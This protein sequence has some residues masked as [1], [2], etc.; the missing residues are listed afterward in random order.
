MNFKQLFGP[1]IL[2]FF[3]LTP[4]NRI[5]A[6]YCFF[7]LF[8]LSSAQLFSLKL[9][10]KTTQ[11]PREAKQRIWIF[12]LIPAASII[13]YIFSPL[14]NLSVKTLEP[15]SRWLLFIPIFIATLHNRLH[16][17]WVFTALCIYCISAFSKGL[18]ET[19]FATELWRRA[20]GDENPNPFGM[21]NATVSLMLICYLLYF[22]KDSNRPTLKN[23]GV[24]SLTC[25]CI[26]L[27][28]ISTYLTG[29]RTALF[30]L[31]IGTLIFLI[32]NIKS[33]LSWATIIS[34]IILFSYL[35][36]TP[37][38][39]ILKEKIKSIP[40]KTSAFLVKGDQS[41]KLNSTGQRLE[42]WR[43]SIC[44]F[45][46]HPITGTGPRSAR[47]AFGEYGGEQDCDLT[48]SIKPGPRQTH[49]LFFNTLLTLG[50]LGIIVF[51]IL[52]ILLA[53]T[54]KTYYK[55]KNK[56]E[57]IG[58]KLI[59]VYILGMA[60]NGIALDMW[61]RNYMVNKNLMLLLLP[62]ITLYST[63]SKNRSLMNATE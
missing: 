22:K 33:K 32:T 39:H 40:N 18:I 62:Y 42:Q 16:A 59:F 49:S 48:L 55:S 9:N 56:W 38:G 61:F 17:N 53:K 29:T 54:V 12:A 2:G 35:L 34:S 7:A 28:F 4:W 27:G 44:G 11:I 25:T 20:W 52:F 41:S 36:S 57:R 3:L 47:E 37:S 45:L 30:L 46:K 15:D 13:S 8:I 6:E 5:W 50:L 43:G 31:A 58:A 60:I 21:F 24:T 14:D 10:K 19:K 63:P 23:I 26:T 51:S 1:L